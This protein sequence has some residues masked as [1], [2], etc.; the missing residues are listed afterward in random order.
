LI[1]NPLGLE[2]TY[3]DPTH[4]HPI[5]NVDR[6]RDLEALTAA[7]TADGWNGPPVVAHHGTGLTGVHRIHA[8]RDA[9][10]EVPTVQAADLFAAAGVPFDADA[11]VY[12]LEPELAALYGQLPDTVRIAYGLD[13]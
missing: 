11:D 12:D 7:M 6:H 3:D 9:G 13:A 2:I 5:H 10:I 8:A 4:L 1:D